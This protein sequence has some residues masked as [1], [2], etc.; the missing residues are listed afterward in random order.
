MKNASLLLISFCL[1][2]VVIQTTFASSEIF[3]RLDSSTNETVVYS[4]VLSPT[5]NV[6]VDLTDESSNAS[7]AVTFPPLGNFSAEYSLAGSDIAEYQNPNSTDSGNY[8]DFGFFLTLFYQ[9][10]TKV[11]D[12]KF[13]TPVVLKLNI[14][15]VSS[16][17]RLF[18]YNTTSQNWEDAANTCATYFSQVVGNLLEVHVC[19]FTQFGVFE[20]TT[21]ATTGPTRL[22]L[23]SSKANGGLIA[24]VIIIPILIVL[25]IIGLVA[26]A[27]L[28]NPK[29]GGKQRDA[30]EVE[31]KKKKKAEEEEPPK[32][33][34][35]SVSTGEVAKEEEKKRKSS[36]SSSSSSKSSSSSEDV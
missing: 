14:S 26:W 18:L 22:Q 10:G 2:T 1:A 4:V 35:L 15:G 17:Y 30:N 33:V 8:K 12:A 36:S 29:S 11:Y 21:A 34:E 16:N 6:T 24:A 32:P 7:L 31:M 9:N 5:Q 28:K 3:E 25:I 27:L 20:V 19:H 13:E 23:S